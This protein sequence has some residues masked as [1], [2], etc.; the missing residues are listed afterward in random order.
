[1]YLRSYDRIFK[2]CVEFPPG[3][4]SL[5]EDYRI[6]PAEIEVEGQVL[7]LLSPTD[8]V[9]DRLASYIHWGVRDCFDQAVL[10]ARRQAGQ[11]DWKAVRAWCAHEGSA[12][13]FEKL[14]RSI[15]ADQQ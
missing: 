3:P 13:T 8:C 4:L 11:V 1:M 7:K 5:G 6:T 10:V 2:S 9:K 14:E 15:A 12:A